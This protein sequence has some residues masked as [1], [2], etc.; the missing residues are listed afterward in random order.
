ML[1]Y[2]LKQYFHLRVHDMYL[3]KKWHPIFNVNV[4]GQSCLGLSAVLLINPE[5][6]VTHD[7]DVCILKWKWRFRIVWYVI[8]WNF[9]QLWIFLIA[10]CFVLN[11]PDCNLWWQLQFILACNFLDKNRVL[12]YWSAEKMSDESDYYTVLGI[13]RN[14]SETDIK[15]ALVSARCMEE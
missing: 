8:Y 14:A 3:I 4:W 9:C 15:K 6:K 11:C 10:C 7:E 5:P 1:S 2:C 12:Q 13:A